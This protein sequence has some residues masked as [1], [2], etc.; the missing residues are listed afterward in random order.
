MKL[1][2]EHSVAHSIET[3][4][5]FHAC[6]GNLERLL[7]DWPGFRILRHDGGIRPGDEMWIEQTI[8]GCVP[9]VMGFRHTIYEPPGR[10]GEHMIHGPFER[11]EHVEYLKRT[12]ELGPIGAV[13]VLY[14]D[15]LYGPAESGR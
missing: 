2:F 15:L 3:V 5:D 13:P 9:V 11:F 14:G 7:G 6:P 12:E 1:R 8:G 4:F 10:F